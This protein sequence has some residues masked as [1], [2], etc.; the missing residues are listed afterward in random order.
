[1]PEPVKCWID[2]DGWTTQTLP[3]ADDTLAVAVP[4]DLLERLMNGTETMD[5]HLRVTTLIRELRE[6]PRAMADRTKDREAVDDL[7]NEIVVAGA[8]DEDPTLSVDHARRLLALARAHLAMLEAGPVGYGIKRQ[9]GGMS[10]QLFL[11]DSQWARDH[12]GLHDAFLPLYA[13]PEK[14]DG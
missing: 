3:Q 4:I 10:R 9:Q 6:E 7:H 8:T 11:A 2:P 14:S 5:E 1:M 13:L 12:A